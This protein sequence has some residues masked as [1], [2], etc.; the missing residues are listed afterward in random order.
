[1]LDLAAAR[2]QPTAA[3]PGGR[4]TR[5]ACRSGDE[6]FDAVVCQFGVMFFPDKVAGLPGGAARA[7]A[8]RPFF[9]NV[10][11]HIDANEFEDVVT[12]AMAAVFPDDPPLLP[13]AHA[14]RL[15]RH[16][17]RSAKTWR[18]RASRRFRS[19]RSIARAGGFAA[20]CR[21]RPLPG[22]AAEK[23][24]RGARPGGAWKRA[25][26][27]RPKPWRSGAETAPSKAASGPTS[28]R[29]CP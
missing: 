9:F 28:S 7:P 19:S 12:E 14:A 25:T 24:D 8:G 21:H 16:R 23:R 6:A 22:N 4:P 26:E 11:D 27:R 15:S 3:L 29:R 5:S 20:G 2:Q 1:M 13:G 10:W 18:R 17:R